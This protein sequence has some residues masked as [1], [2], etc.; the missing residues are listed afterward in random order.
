MK[1]IQWV[2]VLALFMLVIVY[3]Y[4]LRTLLL[5]RMMIFCMGVFGSAMVLRP[6]WADKLA[7]VFGVG[8]GADFIFYFCFLGF[9]FLCLLLWVKMRNLEIQV[10][11]L[12]RMLA[13]KEDQ[14]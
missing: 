11:K 2:L 5:D 13:L 6:D 3:F 1:L 10:T 8:R 4:R 7:K 14:Q 9:G 12:V